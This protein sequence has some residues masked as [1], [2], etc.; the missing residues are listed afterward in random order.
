MKLLI[1]LLNEEKS[2][3]IRYIETARKMSED[4]IGGSLVITKDSQYYH[5]RVNSKTHKFERKYISKK[6]RKFA[7]RLAN[8]SFYKKT[9]KIA[10]KYINL[11][12]KLVDLYHNYDIANCYECLIPQR[13]E[14]VKPI[15]KTW[16]QTLDEWKKKE[17]IPSD[18]PFGNNEIYTKTGVRVRSKSE[19]MFADTL[20][21]Y[22]IEY[23][24]ECPLVLKNGKVIYPDFTI[25]IKVGNLAKEVYLEHF[26]MMDD[27]EYALSAIKKIEQYTSNDI[28]YGDNL[29]F[30][31]ESSKSVFN[32]RNLEIIIKKYLL[33]N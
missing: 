33:D 6:D 21:E 5:S 20:T 18:Y 11:I 24:Y 15:I 32:Q 25:L 10:N 27:K 19:K 3:Y 12:D 22:G 16:E 7:E 1:K 13:K 26:G 2:K 8:K 23:K 30:S 9:I 28:I 17:Y 14:L 29:F 4:T 31:F